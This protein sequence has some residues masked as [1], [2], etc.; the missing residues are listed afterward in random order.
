MKITDKSYFPWLLPWVC[1]CVEKQK[2]KPKINS[3]IAS[4]TMTE[5]NTML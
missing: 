1:L 4:S 3:N 2:N 5:I